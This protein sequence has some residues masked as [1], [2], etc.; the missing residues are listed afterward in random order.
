[1]NNMPISTTD[2]DASILDTFVLDAP[3]CLSRNEMYEY[4][5]RLEK[6]FE[7][8]QSYLN[9]RGLWDMVEHHVS[10]LLIN[11]IH[12]RWEILLRHKNDPD[13]IA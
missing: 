3:K 2:N 13:Y 10:P 7:L 1:M 12:E 8:I 9:S 4:I 11:P 5:C 6:E